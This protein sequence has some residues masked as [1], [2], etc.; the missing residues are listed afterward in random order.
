MS[1]QLIPTLSSRQRDTIKGFA[2]MAMAGDHV[3]SAFQSD[4]LWLNLIGRCAFPLFA[5]ASAAN[6]AGKPTSQHS[7]NRL[8]LLAFLAQPGYWLAFRDAGS[9]WWELNILFTFAVT[10]QS[11]R[12]R[13]DMTLTCGL[14]AIISLLIY[15]PLSSASYGLPGIL[16][17]FVAISL[18]QV[19]QTFQSALFVLWLGLVALLNAHHGMMMML[20]GVLLTLAVLCCVHRFVPA[21]DKRLKCGRWVAHGYVIHL[22]C[23][24]LLLVFT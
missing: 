23:L 9:H 2:F 8:W 4:M 12:F 15:L 16:M 24:G 13:E 17:L 14:T 10:L 7:I 18:F 19:R 20:A 3:A 6:R 11:V 1:V 21:S 22:M 5:L